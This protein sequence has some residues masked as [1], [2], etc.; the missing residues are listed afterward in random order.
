MNLQRVL[1]LEGI[2]NSRFIML[3]S[4]SS[5]FMNPGNFQEI[6][7]PQIGKVLPGETGFH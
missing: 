4:I 6:R 3:E 5:H 2:F 7:V 1:I